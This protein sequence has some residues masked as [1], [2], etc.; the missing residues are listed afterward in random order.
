MPIAQIKRCHLSPPMSILLPSFWQVL[1]DITMLFTMYLY[2]LFHLQAMKMIFLQLFL[3]CTFKDQWWANI[4]KWTRTN[5]RIYSDATLCTEWI[6]EYI[7]MQH[8]YW[9]NTQIYSYSGN[10]TNRNTNNIRGS[11]YSNIRIFVPFTD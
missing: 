2:I 5:I 7:R 9:T 8:I 10:S 11:F 1:H 4:I 3:I 6:S